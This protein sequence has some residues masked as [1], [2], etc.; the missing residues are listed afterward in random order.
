MALPDRP[1]PATGLR[2]DPSALQPLRCSA[3]PVGPLPSFLH[4][5]VLVPADSEIGL[6]GNGIRAKIGLAGAGVFLL[7]LTRISAMG[8][9]RAALYTR[10]RLRGEFLVF[11]RDVQRIVGA[12]ARNSG[13]ST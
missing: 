11:A 8:R 5:R 4:R 10:I 13:L 9:D 3:Y 12:P 7:A 2:T 6:L 1:G